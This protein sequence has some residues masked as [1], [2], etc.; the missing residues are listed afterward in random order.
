MTQAVT[1]LSV[2]AC[3]QSWASHGEI[4]GRKSDTGTRILL[5]ISLHQCSVV[6][7]IYILHLVEGQTGKACKT[8]T[9][10]ML[11]WRSDSTGYNITF[12][13][14]QKVK[15]VLGMHSVLLNI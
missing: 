5:S 13:M 4:H 7:S 11:V 10:A 14:L 8:A 3:I 6:I 9:K 15:Y 1:G 2:E 12:S